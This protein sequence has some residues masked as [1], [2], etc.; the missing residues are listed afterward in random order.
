MELVLDREVADRRI[1]PA[2]DLN[3]SGTRKEELLLTEIELN[4]MYLLRNFC[5]DMP[6]LEAAQFLLERMKRY[7][8][9]ADFLD[10]MAQGG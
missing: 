2:V 5:G 9:N 1:F 4:R 7:E 3:R 10:A 6:P 8:T